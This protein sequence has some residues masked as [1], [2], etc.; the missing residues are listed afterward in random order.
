M[1]EAATE[2]YNGF[3][4][5]NDFR[6]S[7]PLQRWVNRPTSKPPPTAPAKLSCPPVAKVCCPGTLLEAEIALERVASSISTRQSRNCKP[8]AMKTAVSTAT[9]A[10]RKLTARHNFKTLSDINANRYSLRSPAVVEVA[11]F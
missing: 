4:A 2:A 7:R 9:Q 11:G 8:G 10:N 1:C 3:I 5:R 6:P